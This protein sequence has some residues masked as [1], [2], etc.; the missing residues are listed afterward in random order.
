LEE[1]GRA[2]LDI[3]N[4][5][6]RTTQDLADSAMSS[7]AGN[8][9]GLN[10][11][12]LMLESGAR[13]SRLQARQLT[14][15]RGLMATPDGRIMSAPVATNF[16]RGHS[17]FEYLA[18]TF[19]ARRGLAD[20]SLKTAEAGFLYK[21]IMNA[22]QDV[23]ITEEDCGA[24]RGLRKT[25]RRDDGHVWLPLNERIIGRTALGDIRTPGTGEVIV[26]AGETI[27][28]GKARAVEQA[29]VHEVT[30]RSPAMCRTGDG[31]CA[32]CYGLDLSTWRSPRLNTAAGVL[33]AQSIG[34]PATQ[35]TMRTFALAQPGRKRGDIIGGLPRL[36][37]LLEAWSKPEQTDI[38]ERVK[39]ES[40]LEQGEIEAATEFL[41]AEMQCVYREQG[42]RVDDRHFEV[43]LRQMLQG[44]LMGIS[45]AAVVT[46]DFF[47]AGASHGGVPAVANAA[48]RKQRIPLSS[49]RTCTAFGKRIPSP[50]G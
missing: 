27:D 41:L 9:G 45:E 44:R 40:L 6:M 36:E 46:G 12:H 26:K 21:K 25:S 16:L 33:A 20:T 17:P 30:V 1:E 47:A 50:A 34:E 10:A 35:L 2:P 18:A 24:D 32:K 13:G 28:R 8:R 48:A 43:V 3:Q 49:I 7:L 29:G 38:K 14:A 39:V 31:I 22:V 11:L 5:W 4:H 23:V 42:V 15:I 19:G 37:Q